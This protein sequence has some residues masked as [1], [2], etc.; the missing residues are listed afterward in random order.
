MVEVERLKKKWN[1]IQNYW[2]FEGHVR[3]GPL[4]NVPFWL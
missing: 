4:E 3:K 1:L 2:L